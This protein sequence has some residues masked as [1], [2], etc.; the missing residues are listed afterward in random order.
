MSLSMEKYRKVVTLAH[1]DFLRPNKKVG[2]T[3]ETSCYI[4]DNFFWAEVG[5]KWFH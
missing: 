3:E 4:L 5:A 1:S 2:F